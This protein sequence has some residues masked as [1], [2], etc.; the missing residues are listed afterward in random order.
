VLVDETVIKAKGAP[1]TQ[2]WSEIL[3]GEEDS[4]VLFQTILNLRDTFCHLSIVEG[5][6]LQDHT[7]AI[8]FICLRCP[9]SKVEGCSMVGDKTITGTA[10]FAGQAI[11][12]LDN[13]LMEFRLP[14]FP[15]DHLL[16]L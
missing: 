8:S 5:A 7:L 14:M 13:G 10:K 15:I 3:A 16:R 11:G 2:Y 12:R 4:A 1:F 9:N 6:K